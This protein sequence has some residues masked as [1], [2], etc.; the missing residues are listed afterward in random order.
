M[1]KKNKKQRQQITIAETNES[2]INKDKSPIIPQRSKLKQSIK[3]YER[4]LTEKQ[5]KFIELSLDK[6][7]KIIFV[8][9]PAGT[10]KAQ[11]L[12]SDILGKCG[13]IKMKDICINDEIFGED[14]KLH[15]IISLH[16]QGIKDIY[17]ISFSDGTSTECTEDHL[18]KTTTSTDRNQRKWNNPKEGKIKTTKEIMDT[19]YVRSNTRLNH[20]IPITNPI[21][22][23]K[24][25]HIISPYIM[26]ALL[27]DGCF[28]HVGYIS[29]TSNDMEI[30]DRINNELPLSVELKKVKSKFQYNISQKIKERGGNIITKE[31][32]NLKLNNLKPN[33]KF[34]PSS[35]K[36][37]SI[38]N[39]IELLRGLLDTDGH[40]NKITSGI[41]YTTTSKQLS[42]DI[43]FI[44][45]SLGGICKISIRENFY[46]YLGDKKQGLNSYSM[47]LCLPPNINPFHLTRK[48]E[49]IIP[50]TKYVPI[51]YITGVNFVGKKE[52]QCILVD[53]KSH[54]YLTN[55]F[56]VTHN[57][58]LSILSALKMINDKR[59]SDLVYIRSA[60]ECSDNKLGFL[61]GEINDKMAPYIQP[62]MDKLIEF[63]PKGD[64]DLLIKEERVSSIPIGFLRG[65]NWNAK[66]I[67]ADEAQNMSYKELFTLITRIGEFSKVFILGDSTQSDING[68][69]GFIKM[70]SHFDD[71]ES[72]QNG[73]HIFRFETDDI[74][75]SGLVRFIIEKL[76]KVA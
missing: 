41:Y 74:V 21:C 72:R 19:L 47:C 12:D 52:C 65:L 55:N 34:I 67:I 46:T 3:I 36:F 8:S 73:I 61:P 11:P 1:M 54:L 51:R 68:K 28:R 6:E 57:T 10:S 76:N 32:L 42:E 70:I 63:L 48:K 69:S 39:R 31:I 49:L 58:F 43:R 15:K 33:N 2:T 75:R 40:V 18:W 62:L 20:A 71:E 17:K 66:A 37:D 27:G 59:V 25:P 14:G 44:V 56:I 29:F 45:E 60:V 26:G 4:D 38:E 50:K 30:V 24:I 64:I 22:F 5:K 23:N 16:P 53:N 35:Y 9:G 7:T 13:W